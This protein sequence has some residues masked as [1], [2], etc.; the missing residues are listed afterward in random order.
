MGAEQITPATTADDLRQ[1]R[2][3]TDH[4]FSAPE[5]IPVSFLYNGKEVRGIPSEWNPVSQTHRIDANILETVFEGTDPQTGLNLRVE[6][7]H[8]TD[9]PVVEWTA[10]LTNNG[11]APTPII[12]D[13]QGLDGTFAGASPV[14][15]HCNGDFNSETGYTPQDTSLEEGKALTFA[16]NWRVGPATGRFPTSASPSRSVA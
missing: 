16:P 5:N 9:Y 1:S 14:L 3:W 6:C 8:Y 2:R 4:F 7:L 12:S 15:N 11:S 10:W 13:L